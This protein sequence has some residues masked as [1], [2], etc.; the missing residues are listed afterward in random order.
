V[1]LAAPPSLAPSGFG[2]LTSI[3]ALRGFAIC[4]VVLYHVWTDLR[5]PNVYPVQGD[6]FRAAGSRLLDG[7]VL[8]ATAA[9]ANAFLRVG[10]LGVPLFMLLSGLSLT[11]SVS[12]PRVANRWLR[13]TVRRLRRV[14]IPYWFGFALA[15]AFALA[16]ACLQWL[17]HGGDA[18]ATYVRHGDIPL[19]G[20]QLFAGALVV[21][22]I[23]RSE[24]QFA[25]EGSLWFVLLILQ[26]YL[27]FPLLLPLLRRAGPLAFAAT[28]LVFTWAALALMAALAGDL[29]R[30]DTW[31]QMAAPFRI[32]EFTAGMALGAMIA[33][34][35]APPSPAVSDP[36]PQPARARV[37]RVLMRTAARPRAAAAMTIAGLALFVGACLIDGAS[38]WPAT[39]QSPAIA[40][41]FVMIFGPALMPPRASDASR[42][43]MVVRTRSAT[44]ANAERAGDAAAVTS[45]RAPAPRSLDLRHLLVGALAWVGPV[46][47]TVLIVSEPLR[48]VTH[49]MSA[50]RAPDAAILAWVAFAMIPITLLAARPLARALGLIEREPPP[51]TVRDLIGSPVHPRSVSAHTLTTDDRRP[52]P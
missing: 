30:Y 28:S 36:P 22:R 42:A 49:T 51:T 45:G 5:Y 46:S 4:W 25:P 16:L 38:Q 52:M 27:L 31:V 9:C 11:L 35:A 33:R 47:Y 50:E 48:S 7:N 26:Y 10:Y 1:A 6:A 32:F 2:R 12:R 14:M 34:P 17:R 21:P 20:G 23:F 37:L 15:V 41:A 19:D 44:R 39:L 3:D 43:S 24:W 29:L 13:F 18:Y 40:L 8:G